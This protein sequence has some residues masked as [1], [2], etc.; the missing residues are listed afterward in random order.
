MSSINVKKSISVDTTQQRAF[1]VFT[2]Q[3]LY[4]FNRRGKLLMAGPVMATGDAYGIFTSKEAAEEFIAGDP[5]V[6]RRH[7]A[8]DRRVDGRPR[9]RA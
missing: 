3:R 7:E 2:L 1:R 5:F 4:D 6:T 9:L 8:L